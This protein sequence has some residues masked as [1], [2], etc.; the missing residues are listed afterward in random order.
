MATTY[1]FWRCW[2]HIRPTLHLKELQNQQR[3]KVTDHCPACTCTDRNDD[4]NVTLKALLPGPTAHQR[5]V[6]PRTRCPSASTA[7]NGL[8]AST[9][10][11]VLGA[12]TRCCCNVCGLK[13]SVTCTSCPLKEVLTICLPVSPPSRGHVSSASCSTARGVQ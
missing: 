10:C 2:N 13:E 11:V 9:L 6:Q 7:V 3:K 5:Q 1:L 4:G 8:A 12:H